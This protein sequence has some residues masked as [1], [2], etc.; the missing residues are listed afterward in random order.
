MEISNLKISIK[1]KTK[2][3]EYMTME[4]LIQEKINIL[5]FYC[6]KIVLKDI[7]YLLFY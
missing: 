7:T 2:S 3:L 5:T 4:L 6:K 1:L